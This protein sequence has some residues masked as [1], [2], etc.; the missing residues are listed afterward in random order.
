MKIS[1]WSHVRGVT[2]VTTNMACVSALMSI[3]GIGKTAVL[4]NHYSTNSIGDMVLF[5]EKIWYL[6]EHGEYY[7]RYGI[8]Y[9]L[10]RLYSGES[11]EKLLRHASIPLLFSS[12]L[13]DLAPFEKPFFPYFFFIYK[14]PPPRWVSPSYS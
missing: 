4:E 6:R 9:I 2:G 1:F 12:I 14:L 5:P 10:K 13:N 11:G 8:E 3:G 7:S